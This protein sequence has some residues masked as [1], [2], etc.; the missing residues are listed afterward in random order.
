MN[1]NPNPKPHQAH[2]LLMTITFGVTN[3]Y[4]LFHHNHH[5]HHGSKAIF[6]LGNHIKWLV[7][8]SV[9]P[10]GIKQPLKSKMK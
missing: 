8:S 9:L 7:L 2:L 6:Y 5:H 4:S 10:H 1:Q 3:D